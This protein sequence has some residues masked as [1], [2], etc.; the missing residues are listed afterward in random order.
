MNAF[1]TLLVNQIVGELFENAPEIE[2]LGDIFI[3]SNGN[4]NLQGGDKDDIFL[5][6]NGKDLILGGAGTDVVFAGAGDDTVIGQTGNDVAFLGAG[7]DRFIWNNGDGSDFIDG[8]KGFDV[9]QVNGADGPG[10]EFDL[11]GVDGQAIFNRLN[12]G[13]FTLTNKN[14]EQF[15]INGQDGDDSLTV[16]D[17][18]DTGVE[19]VVFSGGKGNDVLDARES[20][21]TIKAFGGK[22][23]DLLQGGSAEDTFFAGA[24]DDTV[25]GGKG[26]DTAHLGNGDDR[27]IWNNGDGSDLIK[28]GKGFDVTE[29]NGADG[30]GDEFDLREVDGQA[31]FN[32]LNLGL[33]TLTNKNIEQF[34]INGQGG[35]DSLTVGDLTGSGVEKVVF[36]GG[37]GNDVL[38]ARESSTAVEAFG[39]EGDDLLLGGSAVDTFFAGAG[40]DIVVGQRGDDTAYLEAGDDRFVWNNGDGSDFI[41][42]GAGFDVTQVN[43]ADGPGDEFDLRAVDGQAIF[44][45]LNL[46][47][48]TL[49]NEAIEQF[50]INGQGGDDSFTVGDL[51][52]SG[53]QAVVFS[54]GDGNDFLNASG[55][56]TPITADGGAG[57]DILIGGAGDDILIGGDGADL[58]IGGGGNDILIGGNGAN[59]FGFDTGAAFNAADIGIDQIQNLGANDSIVLDLTVFTALTSAIGGG[60]SAGEFAVVN[61]AEEAA[62]SD[63]L[64]VYGAN[65]GNLYYNP[66]GA[67]EGFGNGAQF[68]TIEGAPVL[69]ANDFVIQA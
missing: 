57:D 49:T 47:L 36:S 6:G 20:S 8:G 18:T 40:D 55:T 26:N 63:A 4:N 34:E 48:F 21:T 23:H 15:E 58:L 65:T 1:L 43:G 41:N 32:R 13:L 56:F 59:L 35:D 28:G 17:L 52:G 16:G 24:G 42:G 69:D 7:N 44:N 25:V 27:F 64:I 30:P 67:G 53:V 50:E 2:D 38:D 3:G 46:G 62:L 31:I 45:R 54:G 66:N 11:R 61:S 29:V 10:D 39:G 68:A 9:T 37:D 5:A 19:N 51:T 60:L 12:L 33:F 22:G 14:I